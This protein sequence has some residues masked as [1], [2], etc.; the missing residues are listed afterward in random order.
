[1]LAANL[2]QEGFRVNS[3]VAERIYREER[4]ALRRR[5][6][7]RFS[8]WYE[9]AR[10]VRSAEL[11]AAFAK[12]VDLS[13]NLDTYFGVG[14][15]PTYEIMRAMPDAAD[16]ERGLGTASHAAGRRVGEAKQAILAEVLQHHLPARGPTPEHVARFFEQSSCQA[17]PGTT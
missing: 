15:W 8:S 11:R 12:E 5:L 4:L 13:T 14:I 6:R 7:K 16:F 3:K 17:W 2:G 9:K 10:G 1:M